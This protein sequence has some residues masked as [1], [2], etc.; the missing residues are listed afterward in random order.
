MKTITMV[1]YVFG[2][3]D[4]CHAAPQTW[5]EARQYCLPMQVA[6]RYDYWFSQCLAPES[7]AM[8][9]RFGQKNLIC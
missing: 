5:F 1:Q 3:G 9:S 8:H 7:N 6:T 4:H 2:R